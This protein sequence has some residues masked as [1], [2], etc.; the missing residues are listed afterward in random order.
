MQNLDLYIFR[1]LTRPESTPLSIL[2]SIT[3]HMQN[4]VDA[5]RKVIKR[6]VLLAAIFIL[7][8]A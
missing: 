3:A 6:D 7:Y 1:A 8:D 5:S 4:K 2:I